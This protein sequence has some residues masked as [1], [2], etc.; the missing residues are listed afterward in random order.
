M[1]KIISLFL[2]LIITTIV[3]CQRWACPDGTLFDTELEAGKY[4]PDEKIVQVGKAIKEKVE[5]EEEAEKAAWI[6]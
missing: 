4:C 1:K 6:P 5:G 2:L 3:Y